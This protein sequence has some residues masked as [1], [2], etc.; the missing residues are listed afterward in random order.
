MAKIL[1]TGGSGYIGSHTVVTL[2]E[3]GHDVVIIDNLSRS[4]TDTLAAMET[5]VGSGTAFVEGD[6]RD[7]AR[8]C[9]SAWAALSSAGEVPVCLWRRSDVPV[10]HRGRKAYRQHRCYR[11]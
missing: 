7:A 3:A 5:L 2:I 4:T 9:G 6:V 11:G 8:G 1:V 10:Q